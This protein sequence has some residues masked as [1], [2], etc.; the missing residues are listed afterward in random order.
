MIIKEWFL[1]EKFTD[2]ERYAISISDEPIILKETEKAVYVKF[3][4]D[5]GTIKT[6]IPKSCIYSEE[7]LA[8]IRKRFEANMDKYEK[9]VE[10]AKNQGLK[11]KRRMKKTTVLRIIADANLEIPTEL[12]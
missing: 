11:V 3:V 2:G 6:W 9:L 10:W 1:Y 12:A 4:S 5:W 7:E 8:E